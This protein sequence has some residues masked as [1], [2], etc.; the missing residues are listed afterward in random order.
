L[1]RNG[2]I[3]FAYAKK[4]LSLWLYSPDGTPKQDVKNPGAA[5]R[6]VRADRGVVVHRTK[7]G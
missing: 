1:L 4:N 5:K 3:D 7:I 2:K 6:S